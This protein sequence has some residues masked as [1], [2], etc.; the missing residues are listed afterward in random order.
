M[1]VFSLEEDDGDE[2]FI[3]QSSQQSSQVDEVENVVKNSP[4]LGDASDLRKSLVS[5]L[6]SKYSDICDDDFEIPCSQKRSHS[7]I[8]DVR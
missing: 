4:I 8:S 7:L 3:T 2:I 5:L 1:D 6:D